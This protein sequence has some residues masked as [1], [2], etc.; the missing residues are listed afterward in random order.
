MNGVKKVV[1]ITFMFLLLWQALGVYPTFEF[2]RFRIRREVKTMIKAGI[3]EEDLTT[4]VWSE[5]EKDIRWTKPEKE[6]IYRGEMFD[7]IRFDSVQGQKTV[8]VFKDLKERGLF[9]HLEEQVAANMLGNSQKNSGK[10]ATFA[11]FFSGAYLPTPSLELASV[12]H[13]DS[14]SIYSNPINLHSQEHLRSVFR[15]PIEIVGA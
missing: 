11:K 14:E 15:P 6:F 9:D 10:W 2:V 5:I 12:L 4:F 13:F 7:V 8:K 3:P 1:G